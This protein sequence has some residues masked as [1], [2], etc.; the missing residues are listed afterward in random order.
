[1]D[2]YKD[3]PIACELCGE[4]L[5]E[6]EFCI[7]FKD[8]GMGYMHKPTEEMKKTLCIEDDDERCVLEEHTFPNSAERKEE[9]R[10]KD[11]NADMSDIIPEELLEKIE[12]LED[13][14]GIGFHVEELLIPTFVHWYCVSNY[15]DGC[16]IQL[17][18]KIKHR[19]DD[20]K[21]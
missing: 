12:E 4:V 13:L 10:L 18:N 6:G 5:T 11:P 2:A 9:E 21:V 8:L 1:M 15:F 14:E 16:K 3:D 7:T 20:D 19:D 17:D